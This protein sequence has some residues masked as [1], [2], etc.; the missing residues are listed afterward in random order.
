MAKRK[1]TEPDT[2]QPA[3]PKAFGIYLNKELAAEVQDIAAKE[4][5]GNSH[6]L[7]QFALK[8][9]IR[10]YRAGRVKYKKR[11]VTKLELD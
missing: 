5:G 11:T 10:E 2:D 6:A 8:Y 4:T 7:L 1:Q 3:K 9:F